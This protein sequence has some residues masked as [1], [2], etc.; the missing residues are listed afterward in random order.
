MSRCPRAHQRQ[1]NA[2]YKTEAAIERAAAAQSGVS[3]TAPFKGRKLN[4]K[5]GEC[6]GGEG[7]SRPFSSTDLSF[8][9]FLFRKVCCARRARKGS[10]LIGREREV[11]REREWKEEES[12]LPRTP[13][14]PPF[15]LQRERPIRCVFHHSR[16][17]RDMEERSLCPHTA[18]AHREE[19]QR[20]GRERGRAAVDSGS[21]KMHPV[22][23]ESKRKSVCVCMCMCVCV[24]VYVCVCVRMCVCVEERRERVRERGG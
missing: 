1:H 21:M 8:N 22:E 20:R 9:I 13:P 24:C 19:Q 6:V 18:F 23:G 4:V 7:L 11:E 12:S 5:G 14:V 16:N 3:S 15:C 17:R 10:A 2:C